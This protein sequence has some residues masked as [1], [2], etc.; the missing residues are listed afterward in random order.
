M[1]RAR[2]R[3]TATQTKQSGSVKSSFSDVSESRVKGKNSQALY[4]KHTNLAYEAMTTGDRILSESHYQHAEHYLR[5]INEF[6]ANAPVAS[7]RDMASFVE[8][9]PSEDSNFEGCIEEELAVARYNYFNDTEM[10][11]P[12]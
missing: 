2:T 6:K 10:A 3:L 1:K 4:E 7:S 12:N 9:E 11:S 5:L 8:E